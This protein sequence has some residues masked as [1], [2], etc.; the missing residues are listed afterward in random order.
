MPSKPYS[1][2]F[3]NQDAKVDVYGQFKSIFLELSLKHYLYLQNIFLIRPSFY[4][5]A[6]D[7]IT[8]NYLPSLIKSKTHH[9]SS[10]K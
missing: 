2:V 6:Q 7:F 8:Y 4:H 5:K 3:F 10:A 1:F 9:L